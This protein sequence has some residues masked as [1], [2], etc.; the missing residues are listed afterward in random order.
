MVNRYK[1]GSHSHGTKQMKKKKKKKAYA[2][3]IIMIVL[4]PEMTICSNCNLAFNS[5]G[6]MQQT[7]QDVRIRMR[8]KAQL[9][10]W[11]STWFQY[12]CLTLPRE[13]QSPNQSAGQ[14]IKIFYLI[15]RYYL[16][17]RQLYTSVK[18]FFEFLQKR[19][20]TVKA[21]TVTPKQ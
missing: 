14:L 11:N 8:K 18:Y 9:R 19:S 20:H 6:Q 5:F 7:Y 21:P 16:N 1:K 17:R 12:K 3:M 13:L 10:K 15:K 4:I 2:V